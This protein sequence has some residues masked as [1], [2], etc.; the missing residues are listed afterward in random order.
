MSA[1]TEWSTPSVAYTGLAINTAQTELYAA[2][3][4]GI[5]V[6]NSSFTPIGTMFT[7]PGDIAS[8]GLVPFN[9]KDIGGDVFV[10]YAL[11]DTQRRP[12]PLSARARLRSSVRA[13]R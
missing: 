8:A 1:A 9:V 5:D 10:T 11:L 12:P 3:A 6:Y 2:S 4:G 7:T 13:G